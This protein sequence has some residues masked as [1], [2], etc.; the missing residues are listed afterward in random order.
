MPSQPVRDLTSYISAY[1]PVLAALVAVGVGIMQYYIQRQHLKQNLFEKRHKVYTATQKFIRAV[2]DNN[3][4]PLEGN[5]VEEFLDETAHSAFLF[6]REVSSWLNTIAAKAIDLG[7]TKSKID[8]YVDLHDRFQAGC[9]EVPK[10][11][12]IELPTLLK[13]HV[14]GIGWMGAK[15]GELNQV[16]QPYLQLYHEGNGLTRFV[17]AAD[18]WVESRSA[19]LDRRYDEA[20]DN[21]QSA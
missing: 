19:T 7:L 12:E 5:L 2:L 1:A 3:G 17:A 15:R 16:F 6:G 21:A 20:K 13:S 10:T 14:E 8:H 4:T 9:V 18:A 11:E